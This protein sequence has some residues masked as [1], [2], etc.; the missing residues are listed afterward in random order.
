MRAGLI[1]VL[2][3]L[4]AAACLSAAHAAWP[5]KPVRIIV[6][7]APG[8]TT[9]ISAR[10]VAERLAP[11]LGVNVVV[12][13]KAGAGGII[14]SEQFVRAAP[15]GYT[16]IMGN[17]GPN[18]INYSLYRKL[19]YKPDDFAAVTLVISN[20]NVLVVNAESPYRSV[21]D[22]VA[23]IRRNPSGQYSFGSSG[24]GQSPHMTAEM[25]SQR[26][27]IKVP[28]VPYKGA[29]PAVT[30][31]LG[32]EFTFMIDNLPSSLAHIRSGRFRALAVTS[33]QR[34]PELP[35]VPTMTEA[36][37]PDMV[38]TAWFG[39]FAPAGTPSV[40]IERIQQAASGILR[41]TDVQKRFADLGGQAGGNT[42]AEFDAFVRKQQA[43]W[44]QIVEAAKLSLD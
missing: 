13:N 12:E 40:V 11:V 30:G 18:A 42:P 38:V 43:D 34:A 6:P 37:I 28:H 2:G 19:P 8:G 23:A 15:D 17:I 14:G 24:P 32:N 5:D 3:G 22:L 1:R 10:I 20:P 21:A 36:G 33:S 39:L 44:R 41:S 25:F 29:G 9:D 35:D 27:G 31:L 4:L 16:L 7:A 26:T